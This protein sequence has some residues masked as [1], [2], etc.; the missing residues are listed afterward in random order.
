MYICICRIS[1][2]KYKKSSVSRGFSTVFYCPLNQANFPS[3]A[4]RH[5]A[6]LDRIRVL[7]RDLGHFAVSRNS[8]QSGENGG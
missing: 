6:R 1:I 2:K 5:T 4:G 3:E 8:G 7:T